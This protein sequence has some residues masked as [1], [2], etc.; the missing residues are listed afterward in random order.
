[1]T[2]KTATYK[3][4]LLMKIS[5]L[6][7][8]IS[9]IT[10][11]FAPILWEL[12][13][14]MPA[15]LVLIIG[16]GLPLVFQLVLLLALLHR[17]NL[18]Y[19]SGLKRTNIQSIIL[20]IP[21]IA[22]IYPFILF[23]SRLC[24]YLIPHNTLIISVNTQSVLHSIGPIGGFLVL[25][26]CPAIVEELVFRGFIFG[27]LRN[28]SFIAAAVLSTLG[29]SLSHG[30]FE[31]A[32]YT[33]LLGFALCSVREITGS[34]F[35]CIFAHTLFNSVSVFSIYCASSVN[36]ELDAV[37]Q[38]DTTIPPEI[39]LVLNHRLLI[40][41]MFGLML[42]LLVYA[43]LMKCNSFVYDRSKDKEYPAITVTYIIG[44]AV[45]IFLNMI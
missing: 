35:P 26:V 39:F 11:V 4:A 8:I 2:N 14:T 6:Y 28:R 43:L 12:K 7:F 40:I 42:L 27:T 32:V 44:F 19:F 21:L 41:S 34:V 10:P 18:W 30:N 29:F 5:G 33:G 22:L 3:K 45:R 23:I 25:A 17:Y 36:D 1:M 9:G 38:L 15:E 20:M 16:M 13:R 31:Q 24:E 37:T